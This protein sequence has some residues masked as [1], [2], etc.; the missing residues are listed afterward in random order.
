MLTEKI[1][2]TFRGCFVWESIKIEKS[3]IKIC[4]CIIGIIIS[5]ASIVYVNLLI[6]KLKEREEKWIN[7]YAKTLEYVSNE[8]EYS[9]N[10]TFILQE[11]IIPNNYIPVIL[12]DEHKIA[13]EY[14]NIYQLEKITSE[15]EKKNILQRRIENME[16]QYKPIKILV[17]K[18]KLNQPPQYNYIYYENSYLLKELQYFPYIQIIIILIFGLIMY[19]GFLYLKKIEENN[20]WIG[21]AKETAH[22]LGTPLSSLIGWLEHLKNDEQFKNSAFVEELEK[23]IDKLQT[24]TERFSQIGSPVNNFQQEN[25][26]NIT[27]EVLEYIEKRIPTDIHLELVTIPTKSLDISALVNKPLYSWVIENV[28]KKQ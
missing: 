5:A 21:L 15:R 1:K 23:D 9:Q 26:V 8:K 24:I 6:N 22:Q 25:I 19:A 18:G 7:L 4:I 11:I 17:V 2:N 3:S 14:R 20:T 13:L 16:Q 28:C 12:T 27:K 10:F